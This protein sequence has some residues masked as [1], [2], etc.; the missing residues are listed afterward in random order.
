MKEYEERTPTTK[1]SQRLERADLILRQLQA[2][3]RMGRAPERPTP[4]QCT[5]LAL[6][7]SA[8]DA[9]VSFFYPHDPRQ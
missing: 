2:D 3:L 4:E 5:A 6:V 7:E 1:A 8:L 9:Y